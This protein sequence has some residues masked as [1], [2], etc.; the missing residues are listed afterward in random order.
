MEQLQP[1]DLL[2]TPYETGGREPGVAL[3]CL[4]VVACIA[5]MRGVPPP[6]G[7]PSIE[8]AWRRGVVDFSGMPAG[9]KRAAHE[10][11]Y[12]PMEGDVLLFYGPSHPWC[13]IV[14]KGRVFSASREAGVYAIPATRWKQAPAEVWRWQP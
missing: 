10:D 7:W 6:D 4:G 14:H 5:T 3:D 12:Q 13:A 8:E 9:W 2:R 11:R 1:I